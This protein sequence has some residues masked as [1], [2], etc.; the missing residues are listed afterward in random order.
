MYKYKIIKSKLASKSGNAMTLAIFLIIILSIFSM[1]I[2]KL[3]SNQMKST[4][5]NQEWMQAKYLSEAGVEEIIQDVIEKVKI[6]KSSDNKYKIEDITVGEVTNK[7]EIGDKEYIESKSIA[8]KIQIK[9]EII[10][11]T[12]KSN[13]SKS[14]NNKQLY[15]LYAEVSIG[16]NIKSETDYDISYSI[17]K[18][19]KE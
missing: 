12:I 9:E 14:S 8:E 18:W 10:S 3:T 16:V 13:S 2:L 11:L 5:N 19:E 17:D 7:M 6:I 1:F 15:K 4:I